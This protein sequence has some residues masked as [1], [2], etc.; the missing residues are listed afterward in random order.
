MKPKIPASIALAYRAIMNSEVF[1][2]NGNRI[3]LPRALR[4]LGNAVHSAETDESIWFLG[5]CSEADLGSLIVGAYWAL[6]EW[7][8]GQS[9]PSYAAMCALGQVFRPGY[10][11]GPE[12]DSGESTAYEMVSEWFKTHPYA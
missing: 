9:S 11:N 12:P 10:T 3:D 1:R 8:S 2:T 5:E 4:L 7:H 6:T